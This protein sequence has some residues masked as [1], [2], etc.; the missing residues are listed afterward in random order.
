MT[1]TNT[2]LSI[3][4]PRPELLYWALFFNTQLAVVAVYLF[5]V[6]PS[7]LRYT[8][9]GLL[10]V[11][12]A[13]YVVWKT[14]V[15]P[16]DGGTR[17]RAL[18][19]AAGY[20]VLLG[21]A[22]G[23]VSSGVGANATGARIAATLPPGFG[24]ALVYSGYYANVTLMPAYVVGYLALAYLVYA[25]VVDAAGAA[26]SGIVGLFSCVSCSWPIVAAVA[27]SVAGGGSFLAASAL[28]LSYGLSTAVFL[29][30]V[31][32][33]YWRPFVGGRGG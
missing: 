24:P 30:T 13:V 10:W 15:A 26:V 3:P 31:A 28:Q 4:V 33:L 19:V 11:N 16:A 27:S 20:F 22:G 29:L 8:L 6:R 1:E 25:T 17:R 2:P 12:V 5:V 21:V 32:L 18:A 23:L 9:Y 7:T 14:D